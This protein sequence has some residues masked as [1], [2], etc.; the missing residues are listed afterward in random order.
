MGGR[1]MAVPASVLNQL[2]AYFKAQRHWHFSGNSG[3]H[4]I[5][6][7]QG[8]FVRRRADQLGSSTPAW[9]SEADLHSLKA[10]I[11]SELD[12]LSSYLDGKLGTH[13]HRGPFYGGSG[14]LSPPHL[15]LADV[16]RR[17]TSE[18][19][20]TLAA[21]LADPGHNSV[22][23]RAFRNVETR[24]MRVHAIC[25]R[26]AAIHPELWHP[27]ADRLSA[28][29]AQDAL[30]EILDR[31][32]R[33]VERMYFNVSSHGALGG[34][35]RPLQFTSPTSGWIDGFR[36][37]LF[38]Y[39][40]IDK[41]RYAAVV[42]SSDIDSPPSLPF[43]SSKHWFDAQDSEML[44][45]NAPPWPGIRFPPSMATHWRQLPGTRDPTSGGNYRLRMVPSSG[46]SAAD[47]VDLLFPTTGPAD[48]WNRPW[49]FCDHVVAALHIEALRHAKKR[50]EGNDSTFNAILSSHSEGYISLRPLLSSSG[51]ADLGVLGADGSDTVFFQN[52]LVPER[53]LQ[54]GDH[55]IFWN[56]FAY[57][58]INSGEW[59]LENT[60]VIDVDS[61]PS[62]GGHRRS[63]LALQGHGTGVRLYSRYID[64]IARFFARSLRL[65]QD[66]V[67]TFAAAHPTA[68]NMAWQ[69]DVSRVV[70][71]TPY[72]EFQ[73]PG[74]WWVRIPSAIWGTDAAAAAA[75]H[76]AVARDPTPGP[77]YHPPTA[78]Y[79]YFPLFEP[80]V[81]GG[82]ATYLAWRRANA[83]YRAPLRL[84][85]V[86]VDGASIPGLFHD[87]AR[88]PD[89]TIPLLR[90]RVHL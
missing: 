82:W 63:R 64:N 38:E 68:T 81:P 24:R 66:R 7:H 29:L 27:S 2:V 47:V 62:T 41:A 72:E 9:V 48:R 36:V 75:I 89:N 52:D 60:V 1:S 8:F 6:R 28:T 21:A 77:G 5:N 13:A 17:K 84:R 37:R 33:M 32:L 19:A 49:L 43:A 42:G 76:K 86:A 87:G 67:R 11:T 78:G 15:D 70:K 31:R 46:A 88:P 30:T 83:A 45:W 10:R 80:R 61:D 44:Y 53:D 35:R 20:T 22:R 25:W 23:Y 56:S 34:D 14:D 3:P 39:P 85:D 73:A 90:P 71:W 54:V 26:A 12:T 79:V 57:E 59:R 50:R 74:A 51:A 65:L 58:Y 4:R 16:A 69:G 40:R 55:L 18:P